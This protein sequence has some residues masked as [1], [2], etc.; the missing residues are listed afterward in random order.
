MNQFAEGLFLQASLVLALGAQ[1]I[2]VLESALRRRR[3]IVVAVV[4]T[5]CDTFLIFLGVLGAATVFIQIPWL[6]ILF[7]ALGVAFL[8]Y[9]GFLKLN[10]K[11]AIHVAT[12][13]W[14]K[15]IF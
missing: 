4:S 14:Y 8:F 9:Y 6:K 5:L 10:E 1:N 13:Q 3:H 2:F 12:I 11:Q 15:S 7:G